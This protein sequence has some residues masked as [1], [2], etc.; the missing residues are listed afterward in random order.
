MSSTDGSTLPKFC[1]GP[2]IGDGNTQARS[3]TIHEYRKSSGCR[4]SPFLSQEVRQPSF[5]AKLRGG[6]HL[7]RTRCYPPS[8]ISL[9]RSQAPSWGAVFQ[10]LRSHASHQEPRG[11]GHTLTQNTPSLPSGATEAAARQTK[12]RQKP[13]NDVA[14]RTARLRSFL[15]STYGNWPT[16]FA[17]QN[18]RCTHWTQL[19][20]LRLVRCRERDESRPSAVRAYLRLDSIRFDSRCV[21]QITARFNLQR[22]PWE[23]WEPMSF[24]PPRHRRR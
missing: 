10:D 17:H 21:H 12:S 15:P 3:T 23:E 7:S 2:A 5:R 20:S 18:S 14:Y 9:D 24:P 8:L 16:C 4:C 22:P 6:G 19:P 13:E 1:R 11:K